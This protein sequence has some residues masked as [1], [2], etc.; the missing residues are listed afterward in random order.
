MKQ[1]SASY[2]KRHL[3]VSKSN[4]PNSNTKLEHVLA[5]YTM[6]I[7]IGDKTLEEVFIITNTSY[8]IVGVAFLRKHSAILDTFQ[9]T[10]NFPNIQITIGL[11]D[12]MPKCI[13]K[14]ITVRTV[15]EHPVSAQATRIIQAPITANNDH[16]ITAILKLLPQFDGPAKLNGQR[17]NNSQR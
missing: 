8:P 3:P 1:I 6:N 17:Q 12:E 7:N 10:I 11:T 5:T 2:T 16:P 13:P 4:M 9:R 15:S 14:P